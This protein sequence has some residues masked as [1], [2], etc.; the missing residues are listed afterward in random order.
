MNI[1]SVL[2]T[3]HRNVDALFTEFEHAEPG[4]V[5]NLGRLRDHIL[6]QLAIHAE[7]EE[8][9]LY[10]A[11]RGDAEDDVLEA[12]EEHHAVKATLAELEKMPPTAERFR[13]KMMVVIESV[14]HHVEEEEGD[15]GLFEVARR[16][17]KPVEMEE[18]AERAEELRR[19]G[20][21][22]PHPFAPDQPPLNVLIGLPVAVLDRVVTTA[23]HVVE[24]TLLRKAS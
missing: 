6:R 10:P 15:G 22:R 14:R 18:M 21:T 9:T 23:R 24:R 2:T 19:S 20:P 8:Q 7:I 5:E 1:I 11:L 16:S 13:A 17:L 12:L 3:D 4:D